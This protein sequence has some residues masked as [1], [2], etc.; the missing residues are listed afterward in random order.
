MSTT[1]SGQ[2]GRERLNLKCPLWMG[3][4]QDRVGVQPTGVLAPPPLPTPPAALPPCSPVTEH[5]VLA[6]ET[7]C[8]KA[9]RGLRALPQTSLQ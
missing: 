4:H 1:D 2:A 8:H 7:S 6:L 3:I 9:R 5:I